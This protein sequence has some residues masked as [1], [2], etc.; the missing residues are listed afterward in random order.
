MASNQRSCCAIML[1]L[2]MVRSGWRGATSRWRFNAKPRKACRRMGRRICFGSRASRWCPDAAVF[3]SVT[4][5]SE[6]R[7]D[8]FS[9]FLSG[10]EVKTARRCQ[11]IKLLSHGGLVRRYALGYEINPNDTIEAVA[12]AD[13]G[14]AF[15]LLR[16]V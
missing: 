4:F 3:H 14:L 2:A 15:S 5:D 11:E 16:R 9:S 7:P 1:D 12:P 13:A 10:F 8:A 6:P